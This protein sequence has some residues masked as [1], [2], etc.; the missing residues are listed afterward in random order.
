MPRPRGRLKRNPRSPYWYAVWTDH[1][2]REHEQT[3]GC[4][5][6][7]AAAAWL[8]A[9][10]FERV[11]ASAGIPVAIPQRLIVASAEYLE[12]RE[13][14]WSDGWY[15]TVDAFFAHRVI[16]HFGEARIVST[17]T[18][19]DVEAFRASQIGT[20]IRG[21]K[22]VSD[23]TINRMMA[24]L[25]AFGKWCMVEGRGYHTAN[26]WEKHPPL[27]EDDLPV[28]TVSQS[29]IDRLLLALEDP[30]GTLPQHG[31]RKN[32]APWR[33]IFEFARE[34]GLR[35]AELGRL[36]RADIDR[37]TET[38]WVVSSRARGRTKSRK[39]RPF[40]LSPRAL[41]ILDA[42]PARLDGLVFGPIPDPRRAF[43]R[44]ATAAGLDR[45]WLHLFRHLWASRLAERGAGRAELRD[46]GGWSSSRMVDKY[47]H[48]RMERLRHLVA[49]PDSTTTAREKA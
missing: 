37:A 24:A 38:V 41:Q 43:K 46:A 23:A 22:V 16:P 4:R 39:K 17:I 48:A 1:A 36:A 40:P 15:E 8:T 20:P 9:R 47:T 45:V 30:T 28:P 32:R 29:Q 5:D 10:E 25:A 21:K 34:T 12:Q 2:G 33:P 14:T 18:R 42:L 49:V 13:G 19:A 6:H 31:R 27:A 35:K 26:P 11:R 3:T 7:D 44:A